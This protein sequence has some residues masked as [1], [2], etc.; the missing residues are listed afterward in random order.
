MESEQTILEF[1]LDNKKT[2]QEYVEVR[3][4][5]F[6]LELLRTNAKIASI[7]IWLIISIF[8]LF[9]IFI[10]AGLTIGFWL[11]ELLHSNAAGFGL[12]TVFIILV[13]LSLT[14]FRKVFFID[15]VIRILLKQY[16]NEENK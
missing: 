4:Q 16:S 10:F 15:P 11:S 5:I 3:I 7:I 2:L 13:A 9:L 12:T 6:K 14:L 1:I 8:M